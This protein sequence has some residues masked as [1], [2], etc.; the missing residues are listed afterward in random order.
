MVADTRSAPD[1]N[2]GAPLESASAHS[3]AARLRARLTSL[4]ALVIAL[5][6]VTIAAA[7][8]AQGFDEMLRH[9]WLRNHFPQALPF[10]QGVLDPIAGQA[11]CLPVL[12]LV[13]I[14][15]AW[16]TRSFTPLLLV[17]FAEV[18]FLGGVGGIKVLL[19]RPAPS[20]GQPDMF[21]GG[22]FT[23]GGKG[24]SFPSGHASEAVLIY[25]T[26]VYLIASRTGVSRRVVRLLW[27]LVGLITV[28]SVAVSLSLG[29]HW[30]T[31]LIG[32]VVAGALFLRILIEVDRRWIHK[33]S[34]EP[35]VRAQ[36]L[37]ADPEASSSRSLGSTR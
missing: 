28:N 32:G 35:P 8:P 2:V 4:P 37:P 6:I 20:I 36:S 34:V 23:L 27:G 11:V 22:L 7:G 9:Y 14:V 13:A 3:G 30:V 31:D 19:A 18:G 16:R 12:S 29:W 5:G 21:E 26:A 25:G 33:P 24:I 17:L 1:M 15:I 10:V